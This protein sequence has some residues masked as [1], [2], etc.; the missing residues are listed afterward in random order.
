[1]YLSTPVSPRVTLYVLGDLILVL[2]EALVSCVVTWTLQ[3]LHR[4]SSGTCCEI[5]LFYN[6][7]I[8]WGLAQTAPL[9][10]FSLTFLHFK[11]LSP[12]APA[13]WPLATQLRQ[14]YIFMWFFYLVPILTCSCNTQ[15][16]KM[17]SWPCRGNA[18]LPLYHSAAQG[19]FSPVSLSLT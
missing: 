2:G 14:L 4:V 16:H 5:N 15:F 18:G 13:S 19:L 3:L 11:V 1:M 10:C 17:G 6:H 8:S 9:E 12:M 7:I